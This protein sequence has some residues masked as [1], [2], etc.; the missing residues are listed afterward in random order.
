MGHV[1]PNGVNNRY[2][3]DVTPDFWAFFQQYE[4]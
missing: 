4:R 3:Y 2:D 1:Y